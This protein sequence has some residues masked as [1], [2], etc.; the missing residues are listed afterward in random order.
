[1]KNLLITGL[2]IIILIV[3]TIIW[4]ISI[5]NSEIKIRNR[6]LAQQK[7]CE[8]YYD[9]L[10]KVISQ[11]AQ[12]AE[13]YKE[14]FKEIYLPLIEGRYKNDKN[15][16]FMKWITEHNPTFDASLYK[17]LMASIEGERNGFFIEQSKLIDIDREHKTMRQTFPNSVIIGSRKD[18]E[19]KIITS[20]QTEKVYESCKEDSVKVF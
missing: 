5:S 13:K 14:S 18:L 16:T 15:G 9:K 8:S 20:S 1:M 17:D 3:M 11:K 12:V 10:W 7:V 19:I 2:S 4:S 6:G